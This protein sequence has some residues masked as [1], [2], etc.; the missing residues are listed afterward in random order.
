MKKLKFLFFM[1]ILIILIMPL[2]VEASGGKL[3]SETIVTCNGR[4]YG[5]HGSDNHWHKAGDDGIT[6]SGD[7]LGTDWTCAKEMARKNERVTVT[8][9]KCTDGDTAHFTLDGKDITTRFLAV[10]TPETKHPSKGVEPWGPEASEYTCSRLKAA[11]KIELEYDKNSTKTDNYDR[12]L[13]WVFVDGSMLQKELLEKG[14]AKVAYLYNDYD[15]TPE[16]QQ[17][18]SQAKQNKVGLWSGEDGEVGSTSNTNESKDKIESVDDLVDKGIDYI[19]NN[20]KI[21]I[22]IIA[23]VIVGGIAYIL[24]VKKPNIKR[25]TKK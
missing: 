20:P 5:Q 24:V 8:F 2:N 11:N 19:F 14:L 6:A 12:H 1:L 13:V 21:L 22:A 9:A 3:R 7:S 17:I 15:Y 18:E 4:V 16:L 23:I 25:K 10:D